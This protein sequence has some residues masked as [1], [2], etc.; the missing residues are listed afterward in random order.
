MV[1]SVIESISLKLNEEFGDA[2][3]IYIDTVEQGLKKPCFFI[4][5]LKSDQIKLIGNKYD[6]KNF[7]DVLYIPENESKCAKELNQVSETLY[8]VL[9][10]IT[11]ESGLIRGT[12]MKGEARDNVLHFF[13]NYDIGVCR[14]GETTEN[15]EEY[16]LKEGVK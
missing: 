14:Q 15:M 7:F 13:I 12:K 10:Y 8:D 4:R 5:L 1:N 6:M 11:L 2:V 3:T 9:E 16:I